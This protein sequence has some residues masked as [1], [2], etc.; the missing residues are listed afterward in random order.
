[1]Y[2]PKKME[3]SKKIQSLWIVI[4]LL[5][6][7][8]LS[9]LSWLWF[10]QRPPQ[11]SL[12]PERIE[13][14]LH[15]NHE[16]EEQFRKIKDDHFAEILPIRDSISIIKSELFDYLKQENPDPQFIDAKM[17]I[18][19]EKIKE[20]ETKTLQHFAK[21]RA[22]CTPEQKVVFDND[23]LERFKKQGPNGAGRPREGE[24]PPRP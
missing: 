22:I 11:D 24:R 13:K 9:V 20:N 3:D 23:I 6:L 19:L 14:T 15:F 16:Q 4:I 18:M 10:S 5:I 17:K 21:I 8:N 2:S 12:S 1:M 7:I